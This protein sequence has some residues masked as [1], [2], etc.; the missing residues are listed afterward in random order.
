MIVPPNTTSI[1]LENILTASSPMSRRFWAKFKYRNQMATMIEAD[2]LGAVVQK[3]ASKDVNLSPKP[4]GSLLGL[5]SHAMD[6]LIEELVR[7]F[8]EANN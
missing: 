1:S 5:D 4:C 7:H 2:I 8:N 6:A 3:F